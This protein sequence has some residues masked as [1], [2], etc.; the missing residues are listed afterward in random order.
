MKY[1]IFVNPFNYENFFLMSLIFVYFNIFPKP[2][3]YK[4]NVKLYKKIK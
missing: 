4:N 3:K 2:Y 1:E